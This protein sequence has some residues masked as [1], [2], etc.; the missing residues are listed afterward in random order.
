MKSILLHSYVCAPC[1]EYILDKQHWHELSWCQIV[2]LTTAE[3]IFQTRMKIHQGICVSYR[4][5]VTVVVDGI[6]NYNSSK[7]NKLMSI[8]N[9]ILI[10][11]TNLVWHL[12]PFSS[13]HC[14][15]HIWQY[16]RNFCKPFDFILFPSHF[17]VPT[18]AFPIFISLYNY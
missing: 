2:F 14:F 4:Q 8:Y 15:W 13:R 10:Y 7:W 5:R 16:H 6:Q 17:G 12:K 3:N 18:S 9:P 11:K 1:L